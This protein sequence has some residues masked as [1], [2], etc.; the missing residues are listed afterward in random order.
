MKTQVK[1]LYSL[2]HI[3]AIVFVSAGCDGLHDTT[4]TIA[5]E[6]N[7]SETVVTASAKRVSRQDLEAFLSGFS[8]RNNMWCH[9]YDPEMHSMFCGTSPGIN[10]ELHEN[11]D[12]S[13]LT[14]RISQFGPWY[15]TEEY[16]TL[17]DSLLA[18]IPEKFPGTFVSGQ[19]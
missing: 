6:T 2:F 7:S 10:I 13:Q 9:Q 11:P 4:F 1:L 8:S 14:L 18:E 3:A 17:R 5:A 16:L 12:S 19:R 15:E